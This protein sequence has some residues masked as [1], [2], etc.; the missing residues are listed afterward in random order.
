MNAAPSIP[1][2][3]PS[4]TTAPGARSA[5]RRSPSSAGRRG[6]ARRAPPARA[7]RAAPRARS[8]CR[9]PRARPPRS[10]LALAVAARTSRGRGRRPARR[11]TAC[12]RTRRRPVLRPR[13]R[14]WTSAS[15]ERSTTGVRR[16]PRGRLISASSSSPSPSGRSTSRTTSAKVRARERR[17]RA[18]EVGG[19]RGLEPRG[20][21][22]VREVH[23]DREAVVDDEDGGHGASAR[24][25][26]ATIAG[27]IS[28]ERQHALGRP[29]EDRLARHPEHDRGGL[30]L[31]DR[32]SARRGGWRGGPAAPSRPIPV[33]RHG[34][35]SRPPSAARQR[36]EEHVDRG[37]AAVPLGGVGQPEGVPLDD[38]VATR[39]RHQHAPGPASG[40]ARRRA[41]TGPGPRDW[42]SSHSASAAP[43]GSLMWSTSSTGQANSRGS[44]RRISSTAPGSS[45]RAADRHDA[46]AAG[47]RAAGA[48]A[49][50]PRRSRGGGR[51]LQ[52]RPQVRDDLDPRDE[53]H[54]AAEAR[55]P[56]AVALVP[57]RLLEHV[58]GAGRERVVGAEQLA[59][60]RGRRDHQDRRRAVR[61]DALGA[62]PARSSPASSCRG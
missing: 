24:A 8:R 15:V 39:G 17:A 35:A 49:R 32:A 20:G 31:R 54:R 48:A 14:C 13:T 21:E 4:T 51:G 42:P 52:P 33:S 46:G 53:L 23:P 60:V 38:E 19:E 47:G 55:F 18:R 57:E 59:P 27:A 12:P 16:V 62:S 44:R 36:L 10:A 45:R 7:R 3:T 5:A 9:R 34:E 56:G 6:D 11:R 37:P 41:R 22:R 43:N 61:H 30:V 58:E 1:G 29:E 26:P 28:L 2:M 25:T 40:A 50:R